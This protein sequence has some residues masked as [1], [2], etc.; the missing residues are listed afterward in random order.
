MRRQSVGGAF[1]CYEEFDHP[2]ADTTVSAFP[3]SS[4]GKPGGWIVYNAT[5]GTLPYKSGETVEHLKVKTVSGSKH[6]FV[7]TDLSGAKATA[8]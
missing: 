5:G 1:C 8:T 7:R 4:D 2:E 3:V 6:G